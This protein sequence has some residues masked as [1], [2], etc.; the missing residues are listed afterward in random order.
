MRAEAIKKEVSVDATSDL[1]LL[2]PG[3]SYHL[4]TKQ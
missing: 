3:F 1:R 2:D 4:F